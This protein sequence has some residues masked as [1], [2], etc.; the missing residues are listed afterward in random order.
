MSQRV[1]LS[2]TFTDL[3]E[4]RKTVQETIRRLGVI[5]VSMEHFGA[6]DERPADE[7][8]RLVQQE[9]DLFVGMYAYKYGYIPDG[10]DTSICEME[11][12]A[13]SEASLP[14]F[15][16]LVDEKQ[17]WL[18]EHID[19]GARGQKLQAFKTTL[20]KR[21][22][23]QTFFGKDDLAAKVASDVGRYIA[24]Q[25]ATRVGPNIPVE[26]IGVDSLRGSAPETPDEWNA[27]RNATYDRSRGVFLTHTIRPSLKLGQLF[28]VS[29]YL[30]RHERTD[31]S[32][33]LVA[34]FFLGKYWKNKVF[35]AVER[36]GFIGISTAAYGS[37]LCICRITFADGTQA[38]LE[39][40]I[41]FEMHRTGGV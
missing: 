39:R 32:D 10:T 35:P 21:H 22:I 9:S 23:C 26:D 36:D 17:P 34:E 30:I 1:F 19:A 13:A 14:R 6:R 4:Y 24:T 38:D 12:K 27:R 29:I 3:A 41:D 25:N 15:V 2:S 7:C 16:Y 28:D 20:L 18:F 5:D 11:Y 8:L 33:I 31:L 37:F 40:Y